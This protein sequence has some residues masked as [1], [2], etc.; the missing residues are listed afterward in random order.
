[1]FLLL[2]APTALGSRP[3]K[4]LRGAEMDVHAFSDWLSS[5]AISQVIQTTSWAIPGIQ[6]VHIVSL[7]LLFAC[8]LVVTL[9][10]A[11]RGLTTE[12]IAQLATRFTRAIWVLLVLLLVSGT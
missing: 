5:T 7:A 3:S 12:P 1:M 4:E 2:C 6:T 10:F 11:G 9:R 8:A